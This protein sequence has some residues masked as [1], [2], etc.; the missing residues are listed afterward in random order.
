MTTSEHLSSILQEVALPISSTKGCRSKFYHLRLRVS[1]NMICTHARE[2]DTCKGDSGGP[3]NWVDPETARTYLVGITS[4]GKGC[5][6]PDYPGIYTK[7][8]FSLYKHQ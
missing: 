5:A 2:R 4:W 7:V 3:L 1:E 6:R 8:N